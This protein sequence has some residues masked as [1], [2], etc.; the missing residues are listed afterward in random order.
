M[1]QKNEMRLIG[2]AGQHVKDEIKKSGVR[3]VEFDLCYSFPKDSGEESL[4]I[5]VK[6]FGKPNGYQYLCDEASRISKGT[7]VQ[8]IGPIKLRKYTGKDG[9][10]KASLEMIANELLII[11]KTHKPSGLKPPAQQEDFFDP[12]DVPF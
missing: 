3:M 1:T 6:V 5:K 4:W 7:N 8:V 12:T 9:Q 10:P 2:H 11:D